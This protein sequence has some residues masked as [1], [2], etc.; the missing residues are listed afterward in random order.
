MLS[1]AGTPHKISAEEPRAK[2]SPWYRPDMTTPPPEKTGRSFFFASEYLQKYIYVPGGQGSQLLTL[3]LLAQPRT[4]PSRYS[5]TDNQRALSGPENW[6]LTA[7]KRAASP[8]LEGMPMAME[9]SK[10]QS[11]PG[12]LKVIPP[13]PNPPPCHRQTSHNQPLEVSPH[14]C[15][16]CRRL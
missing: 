15:E 7:T 1:G 3:K 16:Q 4:A 12:K 5:P 10:T 8:T 13:S 14:I 2:A 9:E 11:L 6:M